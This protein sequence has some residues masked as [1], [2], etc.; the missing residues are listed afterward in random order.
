MEGDPAL[1]R[2]GKRN[3][4]LKRLSLRNR[5]RTPEAQDFLFCLSFGDHEVSRYG[6]RL[7]NGFA[8]LSRSRLRIAQERPAGGRRWPIGRAP[9]TYPDCM[10]N[11]RFRVEN[12]EQGFPKAFR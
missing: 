7:L 5:K 9:L 11:L 3:D 4:L 10:P 1:E 8:V 2:G 6:L 12:P